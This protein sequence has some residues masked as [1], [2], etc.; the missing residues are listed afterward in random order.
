MGRPPKIDDRIKSIILNLATI[1]DMTDE[2]ICKIIGIDRQ[3]LSNHKKADPKFF[4]ELRM[5]KE[6]CDAEVLNSLRDLATGKAITIETHEGVDAS[7][8]IVDK[9]IIRQH[10]PSANAAQHYL[11]IRHK[12]KF[13]DTKKVTHEAGDSVKKFSMAYQTQDDAE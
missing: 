2:R 1:E 3:T 13:A 10:A 9:K 8:N 12:E 11:R 6:N 4:D 7:G 5:A